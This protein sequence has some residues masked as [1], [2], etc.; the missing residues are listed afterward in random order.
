M[1]ML[2][3]KLDTD[4]ELLPLHALGAAESTFAV[5]PALEPATEPAP[6]PS[7]YYIADE[8]EDGDDDSDVFADFAETS[9]AGDGGAEESV[10]DGGG[11][12]ESAAPS[13]AGETAPR[14]KSRGGAPE[15]VGYRFPYG[16]TA[17]E[18]VS[19]T[20]GAFGLAGTFGVRLVWHRGKAVLPIFESTALRPMAQVTLNGQK[21]PVLL[22]Q[23]SRKK[24]DRILLGGKRKTARS[25]RCTLRFA[26]VVEGREDRF[27]WLWRVAATSAALANAPE[28]R[29]DTP[30][31]EVMLSLPFA[32]G[33]ARI[34][35][36]PGLHGA[37]ALWMHDLVATVAV[38]EASGVK[39]GFTP[40][41]V[42]T[43]DARGFYLTLRG[44]DL[45]GDG[46]T[47]RWE[48]WLA[49]A[50]TE[51]EARAALL[52]HA[53]DIAD[54]RQIPP[55]PEETAGGFFVRLV[56]ENEKALMADNIVDKRGAE[57]LIYR[58]G[59]KSTNFHLAGE[60][61]DTALIACALLARYYMTGDDA[62]RRRARL[63]TNGVC[64]FQVQIEE[65]PHWGAIWDALRNKK[66]YTDCRGEQ[67]LSV[68][69]TARASKGLHVAFTHFGKE[70]MSRTALAAAQWL[71]LKMDRF[72][73]IVAERFTDEGP[74][75][76]GMEHSSWV[77]G[78]ALIPLVETFRVTENEVFLKSALRIIKALKEG[79]A[80]STLPFERAP[81]EY[82]ASCVEGVLLV[83][84]E[85]ESEEMIALA[86]QIMQGLRARRQPDGT[87]ADPPGFA[88][89]TPLAPTLAG[90]RAALAVARVDND[91]LWLLFAMRA[92]RTATRKM[93]EIEAAG[94]FVPL[95]DR[96]A[97]LMHS[98][99]IL[100]AVAQ[101]AKDAEA[102]RDLI[103][104]KKTW[105]TFKPD[106][107]TRDYVH[108]TTSDDQPVDYL[109]L[110]CPVSLQVLIAVLGPAGMTEAKILKN[111]R[112]PF[113]KNLLN[114]DFDVKA[115]MVPLGDGRE[116]TVG[117]FIADT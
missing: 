100:L 52:R 89:T 70:L 65:S 26:S 76:E 9:E 32:P 40:D 2:S 3:P 42:L 14:R 98:L 58:A 46:V 30:D 50:R 37:F 117:V 15:E 105:Q 23:H 27:S 29:E 63:L 96:S 22:N 112:T 1:T 20:S 10:E 92:V 99:G 87:L 13:L 71:M 39:E 107:A 56:E 34:V 95:A 108:V 31:D 60:G 59:P 97:L 81:S 110:V 83:S 48:S 55:A 6:S 66:E 90:A 64:D 57:K 16:R 69:A 109:A 114:G 21:F 111:G 93:R 11:D 68:A 62:L 67:T 18:P 25:A 44:V 7:P 4:E 74:P 12:A 85:Y 94:E 106:P 104:I 75:V 113:V 5:A 17:I 86:K 43:H 91:P 53:A 102:D 33:K 38:G 88:P 19:D 24:R 115:R 54:R 84:R 101:R 103:Q 49:P 79:L 8:D 28:R 51:A 72:G 82:L 73:F 41:A 45:S 36:M 47:M 35:E 61:A 78:E 77:M 116:A 80:E